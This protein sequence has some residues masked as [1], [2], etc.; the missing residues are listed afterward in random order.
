MKGLQDW[1]SGP[2]IDGKREEIR[3]LIIGLKE[4]IESKTE[5]KEET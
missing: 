2:K 3:D 4:K 5:K 1:F